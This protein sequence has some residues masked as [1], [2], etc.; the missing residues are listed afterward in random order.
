LEVPVNISDDD[1]PG[2]L[3]GISSRWD[4][5]GGTVV[6]TGEMHG[7]FEIGMKEERERGKLHEGSIHS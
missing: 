3:V 6:L 2:I 4:D 7:F 1:T 5:V